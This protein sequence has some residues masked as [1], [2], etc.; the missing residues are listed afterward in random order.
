GIISVVLSPKADM[1]AF[2]N[3]AGDA[4]YTA[5]FPA[6]TPVTKL[7]GTTTNGLT[8]SSASWSPDGA[9]LAGTLQSPSGRV[10]GV[11]VYDFAA[12]ATTM[13]SPDETSTARWLADNRRVMY[14]TGGGAKLV[15]LDTTTRIRRVLEVALP[16]PSLDDVFAISPDN[17]AIY[18]GAA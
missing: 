7:S 13:V 8:L 17:R 15:V 9:R 6:G 16:G 4:A 10:S 2:I 11:G 14:F 12:R 5:P 3:S 1:V 18:Y